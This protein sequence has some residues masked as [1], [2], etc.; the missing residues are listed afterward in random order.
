MQGPRA[1]EV[2]LQSLNDS[3]SSSLAFLKG[4]ISDELSKTVHCETGLPDRRVLSLALQTVDSLRELEQTLTQ[5]HLVLA[6][7]FLGGYSSSKCLAA[8]VELHVSDALADK[9]MRLEELAIVTNADPQRLQQVL[10]ILESN[11]IFAFDEPSQTWRNNRT[12]CLLRTDHPGQWCRWVDL[13]CNEFYDMARGIPAGCRRDARR[14]PAQINFDTDLDIVT[15]FK[16]QGLTPKMFKTL[17]AGAIAQA[18][19][20]VGDYPWE[21]IKDLKILD[22]GGGDGGLVAALMRGHAGLQTAILDLPH[23]VELARNN[24]YG[25]DGPY[26]DLKDRMVDS[27]FI[28]GDFFEEVP[29]F[30]AYCIKWCLHNWDDDK[31]VRLLNNIRSSIKVGPR[32]RLILLESLLDKGRSRSL[33]RYGDMNMMLATGGLERT[34]TEWRQLARR[35]NWEVGRIFDLRNAWPSAIELRPTIEPYAEAPSSLLHEDAVTQTSGTENAIHQA[36]SQ[37]LTNGTSNTVL[38]VG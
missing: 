34:E 7:H 10:R 16:Q 9:D 32:S 14:T 3:L 17:S 26:I 22:V 28:A 21:E 6:D 15:Y 18:P 4:P 5:S 24:F 11:G 31:V 37:S 27:D 2:A 33:S 13:Y 23:I 29:S 35:S 19:G 12:S 8:A 1:V 20:I 38:S 30:E 25:P 36:Q